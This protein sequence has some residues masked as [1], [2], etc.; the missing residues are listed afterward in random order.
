M[1]KTLAYCQDRYQGTI[2]RYEADPDAV[3]ERTVEIDLSTLKPTVSMPH[4]PEKYKT[5]GEVSDV[6]IDQSV[7]GS[8]TNGRMEDI[9]N[10][11]Q[12]S[13]GAAKSPKGTLYR[14][15]G[16]TQEIYF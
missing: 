6:R 9:E 1:K 2:K 14:H 7:I 13:K 3:Y 8:C 12:Y 15:P 11:G 5:I 16:H 10:G 4:L